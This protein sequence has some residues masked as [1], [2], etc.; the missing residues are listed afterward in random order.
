MCDARQS[1]E[2]VRFTISDLYPVMGGPDPLELGFG[3]GEDGLAF[4]ASAYPGT[5]H[6]EVRN[7]DYS[8]VLVIKG[9]IEKRE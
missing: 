3:S 8:P 1:S 9:V 6:I 5:H 7:H 4:V 2:K